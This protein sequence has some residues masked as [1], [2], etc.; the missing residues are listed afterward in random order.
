MFFKGRNQLRGH[1]FGSVFSSWLRSNILPLVKSGAKYVGRQLLSGTANVAGDILAGTKPSDAV[2]TR[3]K[4]VG[5]DIF[6]RGVGKLTGRGKK[7]K[8]RLAQK[9]K[10]KRKKTTAERF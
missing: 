8:C 6:T 7:R 3:L 9:R 10:S 5:K 4:E 1:G 2:R